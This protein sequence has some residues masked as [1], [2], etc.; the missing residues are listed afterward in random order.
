MR[1]ANFQTLR[2]LAWLFGLGYEEVWGVGA[3]VVV[4][5]GLAGAATVLLDQNLCPHQPLC[6]TARIIVVVGSGQLGVLDL[7]CDVLG[8]GRGGAR[9]LATLRLAPP[10]NYDQGSSSTSRR[11]PM[12]RSERRPGVAR[13][14]PVPGLP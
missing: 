3:G 2:A 11:R 9:G 8:D 12:S 10:L 6:F 14:E 13:R 4:K 5:E 1:V 7:V